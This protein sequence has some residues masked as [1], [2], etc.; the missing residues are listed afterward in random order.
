MCNWLCC[1]MWL[2]LRV[3][4]RQ[5]LEQSEGNMGYKGIFV[6]LSVIIN[7]FA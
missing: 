6:I 4:G 5:M 1:G 3:K 2:I 7:T